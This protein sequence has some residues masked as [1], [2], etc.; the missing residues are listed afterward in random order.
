M[1][2][3]RPPKHTQFKKGISGNPG[4]RPKGALNISTVMQ[5]ALKETIVVVEEGKKKT[6]SKMEAAVKRLVDKAIA[7]DMSAFR[8]LSDLSRILEDSPERA[9]SADLELADQKL[10]ESLLSRFAQPEKSGD[11]AIG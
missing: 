3:H 7:G 10:L 2:N 8:V 6:I 11:F 1:A 4:G 5:R 9:T